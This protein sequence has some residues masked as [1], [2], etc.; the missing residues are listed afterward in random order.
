ML[1]AVFMHEAGQLHVIA[2]ILGDFEQLALAEPI[3]G[4][5]A[6]SRFFDPERRS[7]DSIERQPVLQC[8][9]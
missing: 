9:A 2:A 8:V 1:G 4:L 3:N 6:F 5:H 7:G